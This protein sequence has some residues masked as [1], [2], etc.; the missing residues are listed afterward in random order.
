MM[1]DDTFVFACDESNGPVQLTIYIPDAS[2]D[3]PLPLQCVPIHTKLGAH[4][5][6]KPLDG[7]KYHLAP[8]GCPNRVIAVSR[9]AGVKMLSLASPEDTLAFYT[10]WNIQQK[11]SDT[12]EL[13]A[14]SGPR[15]ECW[16]SMGNGL[17]VG[18][19]DSEGLPSQQ[20]R[21]LKT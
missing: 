12:Y 9:S 3:T 10:E 5:Q 4:I 14:V 19:K 1:I 21:L 11:G 7:D 16:T 18:L 20:W 17:P 2:K 15:D 8:L 6:V 13:N